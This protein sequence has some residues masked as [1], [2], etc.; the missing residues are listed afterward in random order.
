[1]DKDD[2]TISIQGGRDPVAESSEHRALP[3][4]CAALRPPLLWRH[5]E[6]HAKFVRT[7]KVR[8]ARGP[9]PKLT[10]CRSIEIPSSFQCAGLHRSGPGTKSHH[11][12]LH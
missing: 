8:L 9:L 4:L 11:R 6:R 5:S 1:M 12:S 3:D 7:I 2:A 10:N